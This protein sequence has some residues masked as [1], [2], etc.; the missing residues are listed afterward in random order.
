MKRVALI[1]AGGSGERFWPL[2]RNNKPKQLLDL[3]NSGRVMLE[4]AI[5]RVE[6]TFGIES[7]YV[8][9][10][11][12]LV[13]PIQDHLPSISSHVFAEPTKRNTAGAIVWGMGVIA[14]LLGEEDLSFAI[15]PSDHRIHPPR[16]FENILLDAM[17]FAE[18]NEMLVTVGIPPTRPATGY[19][20]IELGNAVKKAHRVSRFTEKPDL[21][22][23]QKLIKGGKVLWNSGMF[24]WKLS[25]FEAEI[26]SA[27]TQHAKALRE[28]ISAVKRGRTVEAEIEFNDLPDI[29]IDNA[30]MERSKNVAVFTADFE[31]DD[32]GSWDALESVACR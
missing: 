18:E 30:L 14:G 31:W 7:V 28:I 6:N 16:L 21:K 19:G 23:A 4:E 25:T 15:L 27:S 26:A 10:G 20:Y 1:I 13:E 32:L 24:F 12:Q 29:S 2:S 17:V 22:T 9:T 8:I 3:N 11:K 5:V